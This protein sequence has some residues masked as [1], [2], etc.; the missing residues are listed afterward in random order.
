MF[1]SVKVVLPQAAGLSVR[2]LFR[3]LCHSHGSLCAF[4][5]HGPDALLGSNLGPVLAVPTQPSPGPLFSAFAETY[6]LCIYFLCPLE[7]AW[8]DRIPFLS[9]DVSRIM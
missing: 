4:W 9:R 7:E 3:V 8:R 2:V 6:F 1:V 5:H